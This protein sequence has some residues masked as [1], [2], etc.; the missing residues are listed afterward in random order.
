MF[1][2]PHDTVMIINGCSRP[3]TDGRGG[4]LV[5]HHSPVPTHSW[6]MTGVV[7][8]LLGAA[9]LS[10]RPPSCHTPQTRRMETIK[11]HPCERPTPIYRNRRSDFFKVNP[12]PLR[13]PFPN[14][15]DRKSVLGPHEG[16][17]IVMG[18]GG[19]HPPSQP[20]VGSRLGP[21]CRRPLSSPSPQDH[22]RAPR[23]LPR[24][25]GPGPAGVT[26]IP[27]RIL[28]WYR[29]IRRSLP[30]VSESPPNFHEGTPTPL[31]V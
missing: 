17:S 9:C 12:N 11:R 15:R 28:Q 25:P 10:V 29:T 19:A 24:D 4:P 30:R 27:V 13:I 7:S 3:A 31:Y 5:A 21:G 1:S 2:V 26:G 18:G 23:P 22:R 8:P 16:D 20:F 14:P 6:A